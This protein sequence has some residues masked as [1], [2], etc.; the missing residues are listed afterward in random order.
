[1]ACVFGEESMTEFSSRMK[2]ISTRR[3]LFLAALIVVVAI[4]LIFFVSLNQSRQV[5]NTLDVVQK[6]EDVIER[7]RRMVLIAIDNETGARGFVITNNDKYLEPLTESNQLFKSELKGLKE[8]IPRDI[9]LLA[10]SDSLQSYVTQRIAF[11]DSMV[12]T[13]RKKGLDSSVSMVESGRGKYYTD[14]IRRIGLLMQSHQGKLLSDYKQKSQRSIGLLTNLMFGTL[15]LVLALA[16]I[17][18]RRV[19]NDVRRQTYLENELKRSNAEL[20]AFTYSVSHDL[21]AP[22]RGIIGFTAMLQ[23]DYTSKL[24]DEARRISNII[25]SNAEKMGRLIDDLLAFARTGRQE[26]K[27]TEFATDAVVRDI[28]NELNPRSKSIN[29]DIQQLPVVWADPGTLRQVW[30][31]FISNA[32]KYSGKKEGQQI[33]IGCYQEGNSEV[34]FVKDNGVGFDMK[35]QAKLFRVFQ[36]LHSSEEFEGTGVGLALVEKIVS[37]HGGKVWAE[38]TP[39]NG[40]TF[41]FSLPKVK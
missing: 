33:T 15:L 31:N 25:K 4:G 18:V 20:E 22:L 7:I 29:W 27:K 19:R 35:Y 32:I 2:K 39:G 37:K 10:W 24:D 41:Y 14:Q 26:L 16:F 13:R 30:V 1:M 5:Q 6:T 12:E 40:A 36:R 17:V 23:E 8:V 21:R 34:F 9:F 38:S 28:V 3:V 11:S